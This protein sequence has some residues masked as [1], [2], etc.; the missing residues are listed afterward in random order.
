MKNNTNPRLKN[1][2]KKELLTEQKER[3]RLPPNPKDPAKRSSAQN[4]EQGY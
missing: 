1:D 4:E 2:A 3:M